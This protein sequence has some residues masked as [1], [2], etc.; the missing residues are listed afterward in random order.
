MISLDSVKRPLGVVA[1]HAN[2]ACM[3]HKTSA[4]K[5]LKHAYNHSV[6]RASPLISDKADHA[7]GEEEVSKLQP[8]SKLEA[9]EKRVC[10]KEDARISILQWMLLK[11]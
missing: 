5:R 8:A 10:A 3:K 11:V 4:L 6:L 1:T 7:K 9:T 2:M